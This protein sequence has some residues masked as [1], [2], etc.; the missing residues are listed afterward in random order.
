MTLQSQC[1]AKGGKFKWESSSNAWE[2]PKY[3][4]ELKNCKLESK[5]LDICPVTRQRQS[6][7]YRPQ[8]CKKSYKWDGFCNELHDGSGGFGTWTS[9]IY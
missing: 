7:Y 9:K 1:N 8:N 3:V 4:C 6:H 2:S 5:E